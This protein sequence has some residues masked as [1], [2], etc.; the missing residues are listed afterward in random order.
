MSFSRHPELAIITD[1][2]GFTTA[3]SSR[4][5]H[6]ISTEEARVGLKRPLRIV[7]W[8]A[9]FPADHGPHGGYAKAT[10]FDRR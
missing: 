7:V 1:A 6:D 4:S 2:R 10:E 9:R 5:D 3:V 8:E